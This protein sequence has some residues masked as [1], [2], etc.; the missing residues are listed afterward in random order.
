V[1]YPYNFEQKLGFDKIRQFIAQ[2]CLSPL[3]RD[4][5]EKM[6]FNTEIKTVTRWLD[7][8]EEFCFL[9]AEERE[10]P[11][12]HFIDVRGSLQHIKPLGTW[13]DEKELF[14][15]KRSLQ[16]IID[17]KQF[18]DPDSE[19]EAPLYPNLYALTQ[20]IGVFPQMIQR[21]DR[22]VDKFGKI[23]D[24]ASP[25]LAEIRRNISRTANGISKNLYEILRK[26][27]HE[28]FVDKDVTPTLRDGRLMIPV[29]MA[30]KRKVKGIV[31]DES[32]TGKTAFIE[33]DVVVQANN[34]IRELEGDERREVIH[35]LT[36]VS[37]EIR[38]LISEILDSYTFLA[39]IDFIRAKALLARDLKAIKPKL[40]KE[41]DL[42]WLRARHPL[43][44]L[45]LRKQG[46]EVVPLDIALNEK[47]RMLIISGPNAG[48]KSVCLKTIGLLQYMLQCGLLIPVMENSR[49]FLFN[50]IFMD[51]GDEQSIE[52]DLSTYSSH[53]TNMKAF[54]R[55][56]NPMSLILIDE[57]GSGTEPQ[58]GGAIAEALL[59]RFNE[60]KSFGVITTHY[61]NLKHFAEGNEGVINGAM[62]YDRHEMQPLF[63]LAIGNP[64]SSFAI[65]I[66]RKIGLPNDVIEEASA[67][68][69]STYIN[70]DK[71]LQDIVRDKRYWE[72]KRQN[73]RIKEKQ[74]EKV[75]QRYEENLEKI[76]EQRK[77]ILHQAKDEAK[78]MLSQA[79]ARIENTVKEIKESNAD[80]ERTRL[81]RKE[82][83]DFKVSV[84]DKKE[85][86][87]RIAQKI[88]RIKDKEREQ[89]H[90]LRKVTTPTMAQKEKPWGVGDFVKLKGQTSAGSILAIKGNQ[91]TVAFGMLKTTV[92][93]LQ[94]ERVSKNQIKRDTRQSTFV[95]SETREHMHEK[96][97]NFKQEFDIRGMRA[98]EALQAVTYYIDD[99]IQ[100]DAG[101]VR[102]LHG[103]GTGA[104]RQVIRDYL[105]VTPGI[106]S[107]RDESVQLGGAGITIVEFE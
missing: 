64:G 82:L 38:P 85:E 3:G 83:E 67:N 88:K 47:D 36:S 77:A 24:N 74:I 44:M 105:R 25:L 72:N 99:A 20:G 18:F 1:I 90:N 87:V 29:T 41:K 31:H 73:I 92:K 58:I 54:V 16:A 97:I 60:S 56:C 8:V 98:E 61:Q 34:R 106:K 107:F 30:Y 103:T 84:Q 65:E 2:Y 75:T 42:D 40:T 26:A 5:I 71:Y 91:I 78:M 49:T 96:K 27:Q 104:L 10:F 69:G 48:G 86:D 22:V 68:V 13:M 80:K 6:K 63:K 89:K 45:S 79:N 39:K 76:N 94:L 14:D 43:L 11:S 35:I 93:K 7:Q 19:G 66:A 33:P 28:G 57:F 32:A 101:R 55:G 15:L 46:K 51:I 70:M 17:V 102:I 62:L 21:I 59:H 9:L 52:N 4:V 12:S 50:D 23:K 100:T 95:S 81:V 37:D 53:L